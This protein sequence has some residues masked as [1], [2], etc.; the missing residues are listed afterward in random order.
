MSFIYGTKAALGAAALS[1]LLALTPGLVSC[2]RAK[3]IAARAPQAVRVVAVEKRDFALASEYAA[4]ISPALEVNVTPKVGGRV[5]SVR[6]EVGRRVA[7]G[8]VLLE[9]DAADYDA[10]YRQAKA[11]LGTARAGFE[12]TSDSGQEQQVLQAQAAADQAEVA[13]DDVKSLY[14]KTR[15]LFDSGA[16]SK[17]QLDDVE[18]RYKSAGIQVEAAK[19][20]LAIVKGKAGGQANDIAS[21]QVDSASAQA[22]LARSQLDATVIRSPIA[23]R[24]SYR[25]VEA[26]E[27]IGSSTLAFVVIDD[28]SVMAEAGLSERQ[29][30][31]VRPGMTLQVVI[32][33]LGT[34]G[35]AGRVD[36]VSPAADQRSL[37]YAVKVRLP[38][39]DGAI[40]GGMIARLRVPLES[41]RGAILAPEQ[42]IFSENGG[43]YAF[44]AV[45][46]G[47]PGGYKAAKRLLKLGEADGESVEIL[48]G[49]APGE[50]VVSE[51]KEFIAEGD[52]VGI[53]R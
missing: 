16:V 46:S 21:G 48:A 31:L 8:A 25:G 36:S 38:N 44:V 45:E 39:A 29:V 43:D 34:K 42:A 32:P 4:R 1:A 15:R 22:D 53:S 23:G 28:S 2:A 47:T 14:E 30:G 11:A 5:V 6:A 17:Q 13:Y 27:M 20:S 7:K 50:L 12:R 40:K 19:S 52:A 9:L 35:F 49:L 51:G 18:A 24:V 26:G 33:A 41:K 10:Q 3:T 37:L